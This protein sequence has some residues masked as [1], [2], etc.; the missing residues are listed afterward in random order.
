M[1]ITSAKVSLYN[2][3]T[4]IQSSSDQ[5]IISLSDVYTFLLSGLSGPLSIAWHLLD[6]VIEEIGDVLKKITRERADAERHA[7]EGMQR[8]SDIDALA[9]ETAK[10]KATI[11]ATLEKTTQEI[12]AQVRQE[13]Q[14]W[15]YGHLSPQLQQTIVDRVLAAINSETYI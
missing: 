5:L 8:L 11:T 10:R 15:V 9:E 12:D 4:T 2:L 7:A 6:I 14:T 1:L 13:V 3:K